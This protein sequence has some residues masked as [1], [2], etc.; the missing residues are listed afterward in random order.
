MHGNPQGEPGAARSA[1]GY[2]R[3]AG[4]VISGRRPSAARP[5]RPAQRRVLADA[6]ALVLADLALGAAELLCDLVEGAVEGGVDLLVGRLAA[7]RLQRARLHVDGAA[8]P[9]AL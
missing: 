1:R 4:P 9:R 3:T 5:S 6:L 7:H 2:A 8:V